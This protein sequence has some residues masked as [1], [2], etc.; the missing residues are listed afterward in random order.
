MLER[1]LFTA[2]LAVLAATGFF[3]QRYRSDMP[4]WKRAGITIT[5]MGL[6]YGGYR[7]TLNPG[8]RR[9]ER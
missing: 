3:Y 1:S 7:F 4:D 5:A 9:I 2:L 6:A 8:L